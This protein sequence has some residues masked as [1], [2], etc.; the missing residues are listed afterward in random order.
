[1]GK[2]NPRQ[3]RRNVFFRCA[4]SF[5]LHLASMKAQLPY[6]AGLTATLLLLLGAPR[7][8]SGED[9]ALDPAVAALITDLTAQQATLIDNQAKIDEKLAILAE[10][11]R[12][13]RIF[14]SRGGG[15]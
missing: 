2:Q 1:M 11:V 8:S 4:A 14:A 3:D 13:A 9:A 7:P 10:D 15:R 5:S 6:F 12:Q